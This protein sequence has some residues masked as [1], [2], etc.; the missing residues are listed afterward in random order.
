MTDLDPS[1]G[2]MLLRRVNSL[3]PADAARALDRGELQLVDV[4]ESSELAGAS[5]AGASHIPLTQ[6]RA[7][8]EELDRG[9]PVAFICH[10]GARSALAT[11]AAAKAGLDAANVR[12]GVVAWSRAGLPLTRAGGA[13]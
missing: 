6:V 9:R 3:A 11:R 1:G 7:R 8:L 10:S 13:A 12:G 4:R 5:V 2:P